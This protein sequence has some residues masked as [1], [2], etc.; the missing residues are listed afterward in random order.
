MYFLA[1]AITVV[2]P[3]VK[4]AQRR[5]TFSGFFG[6]PFL[7]SFTINFSLEEKKLSLICMR[8]LSFKM[9]IKKIQLEYIYIYIYINYV[10]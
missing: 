6:P 4:R 5:S 2:G 9:F 1:V 10:P 8:K 7:L 3:T